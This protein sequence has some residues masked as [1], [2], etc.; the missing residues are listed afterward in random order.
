MVR[1]SLFSTGGFLIA[2]AG[3]LVGLGRVSLP[4]IMDFAMVAVSLGWLYVLLFYPWN[5]Y[6]GARK[7]RIDGERSLELGIA[8]VRDDMD[9]LRR[10]ERWLLVG[11]VAGHIVTGGVVWG[12]GQLTQ[13]VIH[14][15]FVWLFNGSV[16]IR[17]VL[18]LYEYLSTRIRE[19]T[20]RVMYPRQDIQLL[21]SEVVEL[22]QRSRSLVGEIDTLRRQVDQEHGRMNSRIQ[23]GESREASNHISMERRIETLSHEFEDVVGRL[24]ED[25]ELIAGV[26]AFARMFRET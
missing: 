8:V 13:N 19:L 10:Y 20:G 25:K 11:S 2:L 16:V 1:F 23:Q 15:G 22:Q 24:S 12:I 21:L 5:L 17:P 14:P 7:A 6:F 18:Q 26:R 3:V 4:V 9:Q